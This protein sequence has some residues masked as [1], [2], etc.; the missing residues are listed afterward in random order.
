MHGPT[1]RRCQVRATHH[2]TRLTSWRAV[3][4]LGPT[5]HRRCRRGPPLVHG[6]SSSRTRT[7]SPS[8]AAVNVSQSFTNSTVAF[9]TGSVATVPLSRPVTPTR[10]V[11]ASTAP[12]RRMSCARSAAERVGA[13]EVDQ[14]QA[15]DAG[16]SPPTCHP[17]RRHETT[18]RPAA[19]TRPA[20]PG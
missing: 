20:S 14:P 11:T 10:M 4:P 16:S 5:R 17:T 19:P 12:G 8:A 18:R 6:R 13:L 3:H 2:P 1:V 7:R 9:C 15:A